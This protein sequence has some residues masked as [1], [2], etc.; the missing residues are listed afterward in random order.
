VLSHIR[1]IQNIYKFEYIERN[2]QNIYKFEYIENRKFL[3][4]L[5]ATNIFHFYFF[6]CV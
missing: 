3:D 2:I 5:Y 1:N 6:F 4:L